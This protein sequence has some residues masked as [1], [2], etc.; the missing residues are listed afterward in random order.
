MQRT[1]A[2]VGI[3]G[4]MGATVL[5][6][7]VLVKHKNEGQA[8]VATQHFATTYTVGLLDYNLLLTP[9]IEE[10]TRSFGEQAKRDNV[11]VEYRK[12]KSSLQ[13]E[14]LKRATAS[15][16]NEHVDLVVAGQAAVPYIREKMPQVLVISALTPNAEAARSA[17]L[18]PDNRTFFIDSGAGGAVVGER[19]SYAQKL[20]PEL[21][22]LL[23]LHAAQDGPL[24]N[25]EAMESL[26]KATTERHI[27]L[28]E[29]EFSTR[30]EL[31]KF[32]LTYDFGQVDA[33]FRCPDS[34]ITANL[35]ILFAMSR[36]SRV[37]KPLIVRN[38]TELEMGGLLSYGTD[39]EDFG[40]AAADLAY[41]LLRTKGTLPAASIVSAYAPKLG[42]NRSTA[43]MFGITIPDALLHEADYIIP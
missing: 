28:V 38:K 40:G 17:V 12:V 26:R 19:L 23:V 20:M 34:F 18:K 2:I 22:V 36:Q 39:V 31:N 1:V 10:F 35:D 9:T 30:E 11:G 24:A 5:G 16:A 32:F 3:L 15:L 25:P 27:T 37:H 13:P 33:I 8:L 43:N 14:S 4:L 21:K 7:S 42:L 29:K 6:L 41:R